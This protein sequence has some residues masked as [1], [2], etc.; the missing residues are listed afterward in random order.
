MRITTDRLRLT[1]VVRKLGWFLG[2]WLGGVLTIGGVA[3]A[4]RFVLHAAH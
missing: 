4:L 3:T 1:S 2:L